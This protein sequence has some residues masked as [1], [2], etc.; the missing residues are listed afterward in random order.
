M[1]DTAHIQEGAIPTSSPRSVRLQH[2]AL[3]SDFLQ[4]RFMSQE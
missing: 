2:I 1:S 3:L 4:P